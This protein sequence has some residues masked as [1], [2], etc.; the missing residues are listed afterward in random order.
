MDFR[1]YTLR[2]FVVMDGLAIG[3]GFAGGNGGVEGVSVE[4][5]LSIT[6]AQVSRAACKVSSM[7]YCGT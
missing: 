1:V 3:D 7:T 6:A 2:W 5:M 4:L